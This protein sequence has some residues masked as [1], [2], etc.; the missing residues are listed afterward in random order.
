MDSALRALVD[1]AQVLDHSVSVHDGGADSRVLLGWL[2]NAAPV[3]ALSDF[4][5][6]KGLPEPMICAWLQHARSADGIGL[7]VTPK[8]DSVRLY[9]QHWDHAKRIGDVVYRG[10]K[11][12][13]GVF[14]VDEYLAQGD[15]RDPSHWSRACEALPLLSDFEERIFHPSFD[16]DLPFSTIENSGRQSFLATVRQLKLILPETNQSG[17]LGA[18]LLHVAGG[19]DAVK[20]GFVTQYVRASKASAIEVLSVQGD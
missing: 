20:G 7:T 14:R 5:R 17:L 8:L 11:R 13:G 19:I 15:L 16:G 2:P 4:G 1:C 10:F 9:T 6:A 3:A 12:M 18:Q